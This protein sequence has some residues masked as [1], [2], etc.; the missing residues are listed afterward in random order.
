LSLA[1]GDYKWRVLDYGAYGYGI[2]SAFK[3][4]TLSGIACYTLTTT[5][6]PGGSGSV[7]VPAQTCAGGY[8]AGSVIQVSAVPNTGYLFNNWSGDA[9][10][11]ANPVSV[12]MNANR[13]VTANFKAIPVLIAPNGAITSWNNTFSW[14]GLSNATW[15]LLEVYT[16]DGTVQVFRK[17]YTS[18]QTGCS[19]GTSCSIAPPETSGLANGN[20]K[21][22]I[23][24]YGAYGYGTW[25]GY[26][27]F[28]LAQ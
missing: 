13:S 7:T 8:T 1:N 23:L 2:N 5:V 28:T 6:S 9:S 4:F 15:Y 22:R 18:S 17:W 20:Y 21:W 24:D 25:T 16:A 12:T 10:G 19:G 3:N 26:M 11:T 27:N 14:T